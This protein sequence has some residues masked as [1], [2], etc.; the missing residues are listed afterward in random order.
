ML[1]RIRDLLGGTDDLRGKG[2]GT[3]TVLDILDTG[4]TIGLDNSVPST[5]LKVRRHGRARAAAD[6]GRPALRRP[7][8]T[9]T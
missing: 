5:I 8:G 4:R 9:R 2:L 7:S 1:R 6:C 3:A